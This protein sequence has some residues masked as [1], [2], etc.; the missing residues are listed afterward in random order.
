M[1]LERLKIT[2]SELII[3]P[4]FRIDLL[5]FDV[6][7][8]P[9][10]SG[11]RAAA[12][13]GEYGTAFGENEGLE[14]ALKM[15]LMESLESLKIYERNIIY[16]PFSPGVV[17][18]FPGEAYGE[19]NAT[20]LCQYPEILKYNYL[21]E[22]MVHKINE[23]YNSNQKNIYNMVTRSGFHDYRFQKCIP[24]KLCLNPRGYPKLESPLRNINQEREIMQ[25]CYLNSLLHFLY[26]VLL[27]IQFTTDKG[28]QMG[29][30]NQTGML[31]DYGNIV[32]FMIQT[33]QKKRNN[34]PI[35]IESEDEG[36]YTTIRRFIQYDIQYFKGTGFQLI[37]KTNEFSIK[38]AC[39]ASE[40]F[41]R[42]SNSLSLL[43]YCTKNSFT[44]PVFGTL[45]LGGEAVYQTEHLQITVE[46]NEYNLN[47]KINELL[48]IENINE[49]REL[50]SWKTLIN[51]KE[52]MP[53]FLI[54]NVKSYEQIIPIPREEPFFR[55]VARFPNNL[56]NV[57]IRDVLYE[58]TDIVY[59]NLGHYVSYNKRN[60]GDWYY[61]NDLF[62]PQVK[63]ELPPLS[64]SFY[65]QLYLL[66]KKI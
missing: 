6:F 36:V 65:P 30:F 44:G 10:P 9:T 51:V 48:Y 3:N 2:K 33:L 16:N 13:A 28:E 25:A 24:E 29:V 32:E 56:N 39:D 43:G 26:P 14:R 66:K 41:Q 17:F 35:Y 61:F 62:Y 45:N 37:Q 11:Y 18:I 15:S 27:N 58:I 8:P 59:Y 49:D 46:S 20:T 23:D 64:G 31:E 54:I 22:W 52:W 40:A 5:Q 57:T 1:S 38:D 34:A 42:L 55:K 50:T 21:E 7:K 53:L 19:E 12:A 4:G 60:N 63:Q 47:E